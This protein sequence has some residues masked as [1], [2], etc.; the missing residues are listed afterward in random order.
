[1][2][3]LPAHASPRTIKQ[4]RTRAAYAA[5]WGLNVGGGADQAAKL[6]EILDKVASPKSGGRDLGPCILPSGIIELQATCAIDG[7]VGQRLI[8]ACNTDARDGPRS[9]S[10]TWS[11]I[12]G[13]SLYWAGAA[14]SPVLAVQN[15]R[16]FFLEYL[17]IHLA[18]SPSSN[19]AGI[20]TDRPKRVYAAPTQYGNRIWRQDDCPEC[21]DSLCD[22]LGLRCQ[23]NAHF[24]QR[25]TS[26][27]QR[28]HIV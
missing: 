28:S 21:L 25:R 5:E 27:R 15:V 16:N 8:G 10:P 13:T 7:L 24:L 17:D 2:P 12:G 14:R 23:Q 3:L 22:Y 26:R 20:G 4:I 18:S 1:M 6:D 9:W 19:H 11:G